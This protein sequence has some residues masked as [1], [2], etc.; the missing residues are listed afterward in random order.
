M[1]QTLEQRL[2]FVIGEQA[3]VI[4]ELQRQLEEAQAKIVEL[5]PAQ[6]PDLK[7]VGDE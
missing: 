4:Q 1:I 7:I 2:K 5:T 6:S 3:F